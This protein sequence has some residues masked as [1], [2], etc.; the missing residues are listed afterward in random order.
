MQV[1]YY[2]DSLGTIDTYENYDELY[3]YVALPQASTSMLGSWIVSMTSFFVGTVLLMRIDDG[4]GPALV[5]SLFLGAAL[6]IHMLPGLNNRY[7]RR[8]FLLSFCIC[9]L[10]TGTVQTYAQI[11]L[12]E[13]HTT[14]DAIRFYHTCRGG[15][16]A[17]Y[18]NEVLPVAIWQHLYAI[19]NKVSS[20]EG[21]WL[22]ILVNCLLVGFSGSI[23]VSIG[24]HLFGD[25]GVRL[26]RLGTLFAVCGI[27][28]L[29]GSIFVRD[30]FAL[31]L[32]VLTLWGIVRCLALPSTKNLII[33]LATLLF[34]FIC[35]EYIRDGLKPMFVL[36]G[37]MA[38]F[39]WT[40]KVRSSVFIFL[41]PLLVLTIGLMLLPLLKSSLG[42]VTETVVEK[43]VKYGSRYEEAGSLGQ[44]LVAGQPVPIR[45]LVGPFYILINPIPLWIG[46]QFGL[47][48]YVWL[49]SWHG[50]YL[51]WIT[52]AI[53]LGLMDFFKRAIRGGPEAPVA[54]YLAFYAVIT[55]LAIAVTSLE[56]RHHGQFLPAMLI[57]AVIPD[58]YDPSTMNKARFIKIGWFSFVIVGH[59][60]W[61]AL[62]FF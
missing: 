39:S 17:H 44:T 5:G 38:L 54:C 19:Y 51:V 46:F 58:K 37:L 10:I 52:P 30:S 55:L 11:A 25:D 40:R 62:K 43:S 2:P 42:I 35:M 61:Y 13:P 14:V 12:G 23:T 6:L 22:G 31:F 24:R 1:D 56:N 60:A 4:I 28:W 18:L 7:A 47:K 20:H 36:F 26:R 48:E 9:V 29:Y 32:N 53:I 45:L 27:F 33:M 50:I 21:P 16:A 49:K 8:G 15:P 41:L 34:G 3:D 59:L 57:L